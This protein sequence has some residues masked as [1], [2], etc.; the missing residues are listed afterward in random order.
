MADPRAVEPEE[1]DPF[2][3]EIPPA[4][5]EVEE[6]TR[7]VPAGEANSRRDAVILRQQVAHLAA[8]GRKRQP[9]AADIG[10]EGVLPTHHLAEGALEGDVVVHQR[11]QA[12]Q[13]AVLP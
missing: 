5:R 12:R 2:P 10:A 11:R 9:H 4:R 7:I 3:G 8:I 6:R 1:A 13:V